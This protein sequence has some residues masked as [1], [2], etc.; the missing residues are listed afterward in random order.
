MALV[1][2]TTSLDKRSGGSSR[3]GCRWRGHF[4]RDSRL[5]DPH[6]ILTICSSLIAVRTVTVHNG[7]TIEEREELQLAH[8]SVKEYLMSNRIK[9]S[10]VA[11]YTILWEQSHKAIAEVCLT[12][13]LQFDTWNTIDG[14]TLLESPLARYAAQYWPEHTKLSGNISVDS[15]GDRQALNLL[16]SSKQGFKNWI[17]LFDEDHKYDNSPDIKRHLKEIG[18]PVYYASLL[19]LTRTVQ[20][21]ITKGADVNERGGVCGNPLQ[22]AACRGESNV[23]EILLANGAALEFDNGYY[24]SALEAAAA[25]GHESVVR[26]LLERGSNVDFQVGFYGNALQAATYTDTLRIVQALVESGANVNLYG[27]RYAN[28]LQSAAVRSGIE[29]VRYLL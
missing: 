9:N 20:T 1:R 15:L 2:L 3:G 12:Y 10:P 11:D 14:E 19:G 16:S 18:S 22:A 26:L 13:L 7:S 27:G 6:D 4:D 8:Y 29:V 24:G 21:L 17:R 23:V 5:G 25:E 28:P